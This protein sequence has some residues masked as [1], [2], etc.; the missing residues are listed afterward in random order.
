MTDDAA[1]APIT[2][3]NGF[4]ELA[5]SRLPQ[6]EFDYIAGGSGDELT[7]ADNVAA[8]RRYR[9]RPRILRDVSALDLSTTFVGAPVALPVGVAPVAFQHFAHP[10]AEAAT[11]AAAARAGAL[12]CVSTLSSRPLEEVAMSAAAAGPGPRWFQLYVHRE[13]ARSEDL[14]RRAAAAGY[15]AIVLTADLPV[16]GNRERDMRNAL[17][18]PQSYG[19]FSAG[20][21]SLGAAV[22]AFNDT[23]L[24]WDD[25]AWLRGLTNLP[26]VIKGI[27]TA[28][29]AVLAV[30]HGAA[31]IVVS[32]HGGRQLDRT[33]A[34]IEVLAEVVD[35]VGG[36][37]EVY[38]DGG[39]R[40]AVDVITA[41]ALGARGVLIGRPFIFALAAE[42]QQGVARALA[43][44]AAE[45]RTDMALLGARSVGEITP[46]FV[47]R[48]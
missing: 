42:G 37:A 44:L 25:I 6:T 10:D 43:L 14:V 32:N 45:M 33:P 3:L 38:I 4:E 9:L 12:F 1:A 26:L 2:N 27:L 41:L 15:Q 22:G 19:N 17:H 35:A 36:R 13:R 18:Y 30:D 5:R 21:A 24:S 34:S 20:T 16:A 28:D 46:Q 47:R 8:F 29:D 23:S 39:V 7:L 40:R 11:A 48:I 31:A